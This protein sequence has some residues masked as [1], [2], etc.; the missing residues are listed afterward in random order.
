MPPAVKTT[1]AHESQEPATV[2]VQ[3]PSV[4]ADDQSVAPNSTAPNYAD[5]AVVAARHPWRWVGTVIV[6]A[7]AAAVLYSLVSNPRWEWGVVAQWFT[8]E[9]ILRGLGRH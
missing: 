7:L 1:P 9:S 8:A 4:A 5:Y 2:P 3:E 6:A